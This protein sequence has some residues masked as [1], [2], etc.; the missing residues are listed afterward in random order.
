MFVN[1]VKQLVGHL[2]FAE[3]G[4]HGPAGAKSRAEVEVSAGACRNDPRERCFFQAKLG[5]A[6]ARSIRCRTGVP[7]FSFRAKS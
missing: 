2:Q 1:L 3:S 4:G 6:R 5:Q 7:R